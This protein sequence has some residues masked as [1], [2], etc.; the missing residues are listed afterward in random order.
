MGYGHAYTVDL[1]ST[2]V[3]SGENVG[4]LVA[5]CV[6][7]VYPLIIRGFSSMNFSNKLQLITKREARPTM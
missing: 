3:D 7:L 5:E 1:S 6:C 2:V 4:K